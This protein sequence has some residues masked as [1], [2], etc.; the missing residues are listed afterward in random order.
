MVRRAG[1]FFFSSF[2]IRWY[3]S[4][5]NILNPTEASLQ[6]VFIGSLTPHK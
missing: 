2:A 5:A 3:S 4:N 6:G 1:Y